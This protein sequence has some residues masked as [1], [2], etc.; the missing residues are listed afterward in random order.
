MRRLNSK[1][2]VLIEFAFGLPI[3]V[4]M[5]YFCLDV[6]KAYQFVNKLTTCSEMAA[7]LITNVYSYSGDSNISI[8]DLRYVSKALEIYFL[9]NPAK[10]QE[11]GF[12]ISMYITCVTG[13]DGGNF[14]TNW[15]VGVDNDISNQRISVYRS[16][17]KGSIPFEGFS[18]TKSQAISSNLNNTEF[19]NFEIGKGDIKLIVEAFVWRKSDS[20]GFNKQFYMM[21]LP[22]KLVANKFVVITPPKGLI[23]DEY[24]P[25]TEDE[26]KNFRE[27][28]DRHNGENS[29]KSVEMQAQ[30]ALEEIEIETL[31]KTYMDEYERIVTNEVRGNYQIPSF[32]RET[33]IRDMVQ[34]ERNKQLLMYKNQLDQK[35]NAQQK[36]LDAQHESEQKGFTSSL[37]NNC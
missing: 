17:Q 32:E 15:V 10:Q 26:L 7:D 12:N 8:E 23:S 30:R 35:Y 20:R 18:E 3:L 29:N 22:M 37:P 31:L 36:I 13:I 25:M 6:P 27:L 21:S 2:A 19:K 1:G 9:G 14:K 33:L 28:L 24:P 16:F 11:Y 5:M 34:S 4:L